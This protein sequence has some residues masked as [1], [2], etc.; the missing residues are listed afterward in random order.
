MS[1]K[2]F[3]ID[4]Q[5]LMLGKTR[6]SEPE[7]DGFYLNLKDLAKPG[8]TVV[9][10]YLK[11]PRSGSLLVPFERSRRKIGCRYFDTKTFRLIMSSVRSTKKAM[12]AK[13]GAR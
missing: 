7:L 2:I 3:D 12:A 13:A 11:A 4:E 1:T 10:I 6:L 5:P 8:T 9:R